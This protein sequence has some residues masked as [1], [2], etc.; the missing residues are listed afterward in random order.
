MHHASGG[1][2]RL[3]LA[4]LLLTLLLLPFRAYYELGLLLCL[5][6]G[7]W[8]LWQGQRPWRHAG[9]RLFASCFAAYVLA[10]LWSLPDAVDPAGSSR[11][12]LSGLRFIGYGWAAS[13]LDPQQLRRLL[14]GAACVVGIWVIDALV[15]ATLGVSLGGRNL[16]DRVSGIFGD[17]D[18]KLGPV[19]GALA[20]LPLALLLRRR[21]ALQIM[22]VG[23]IGAAVLVAGARAGWISLALVLLWWLLRLSREAGRRP[24]P[25]LLLTTV[26]GLGLATT[27]YVNDAQ[28]AGRV[29]RTL[30]LAGG[31][32]EAVDTAL[33]FRLP[34]WETAGRMALAHPFNGVGVRGFRYAYPEHAAADDRWVLLHQGRMGA[35]H[36]HQIVLELLCET[37]LPGLLLWL[38]ATLL[39]LR[40]WRQASAAQRSLAFGAAAALLAMCFPLNTHLAFYSSFWGTLLFWLLALY[41]VAIRQAA[42]ETRGTQ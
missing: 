25:V 5:C 16:T 23:L 38:A 18:L 11:T 9:F 12:A 28:F 36:P 42:P 26:A 31:E 6:S 10:A 15:Q 7:V 13:L 24:W 2:A 1:P 34:I 30:L 21:I 14:Q 8:S 19:L 4:G 32:R 20:A 27:L 39:L 33:A 22:V 29:D 3:A 17:A 35:S 40:A 37:G 41:C